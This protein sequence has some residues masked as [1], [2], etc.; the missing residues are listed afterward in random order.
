MAAGEI[1][2]PTDDSERESDRLRLL[3]EVSNAV[4]SK[5]SLKDLLVTVSSF[6]KRFIDHDFASVVLYDEESEKI[7]VHALDKPAPGGVL[8]EGTI[9]PMDGTP[10]GLAIRTRQSVRRDVIDVPLI[11]RD[12]VL[13][14]ISVGSLREAA[15]GDD[16]QELQEEKFTEHDLELFTQIAQQVAIAVENAVNFERV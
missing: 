2:Y 3:L 4:V 16:D 10:P 9:L 8:G 13:G 12:R 5:L 1:P 6:L 14:T 15:F 7:H 11:S